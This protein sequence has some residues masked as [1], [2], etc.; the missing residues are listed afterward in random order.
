MS[1]SVT[2][3]RLVSIPDAAVALGKS[4]RTI[5]RL[6]QRGKLHTVEINGKTCVQLASV[7]VVSDVS[8]RAVTVAAE[9]DNVTG[10]VRRI[11]EEAVAPYREMLRRRDEDVA[12]LDA[13]LAKSDAMVAWLQARYESAEARLALPAPA[14]GDR[15]PQRAVLPWVLVAVLGMALAIGA[16][17][18]WFDWFA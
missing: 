9:L 5:R 1:S 6:I 7:P 18:W 11:Q 2:E 10:D 16:A 12:R 8:V 15:R 4:E 13:A 3:S 17:A 14:E